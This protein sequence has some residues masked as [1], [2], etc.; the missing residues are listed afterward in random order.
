MT[1]F[2]QNRQFVEF[3]CTCCPY[4]LPSLTDL[5]TNYGLF[6][7]II[8]F[9]CFQTITCNLQPFVVVNIGHLS[10][11]VEFVFGPCGTKEASLCMCFVELNSSM[12]KEE[13]KTLRGFL[14]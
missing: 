10:I 9:S 3:K 5:C 11:Y 14:A 12:L 8:F 2:V 7:M 1:V 4:G 6:A 13:Q